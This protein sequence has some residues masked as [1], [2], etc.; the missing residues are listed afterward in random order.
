MSADCRAGTDRRHRPVDA[1]AYHQPMPRAVEVAFHRPLRVAVTALILAG[2]GLAVIAAVLS[3]V[4]PVPAQLPAFAAGAWA[5]T[6]DAVLVWRR[7]G[8]AVLLTFAVLAGQAVAV[9]GTI[10]ELTVGIA[11][12]KA[13]QL[14]Q[15][16][17]DPT[18][19]VIINLIYSGLGFAVFCW[20]AIRWFA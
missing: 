2:V 20:F 15:L 13:H 5:L 8:W 6:A 7:V 11:D 14:Q 12:V 19:G 16:G 3:G 4:H 10:A 9:I 1:P 18:L 17:F